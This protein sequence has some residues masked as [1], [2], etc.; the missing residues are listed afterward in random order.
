M[1][2]IAWISLD[3]V[4]MQF[5]NQHGT[6]LREELEKR[7][8]QKMSGWAVLL[9]VYRQR[10]KKDQEFGEIRF[11][12]EKWVKRKGRWRP[13]ARIKLSFKN[14]VDLQELADEW[15]VDADE[16]EVDEEAEEE[17]DDDDIAAA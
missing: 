10:K 9:F 1:P 5:E 11:A 17:A 13:Y 12:I 15:I 16:E 7:V 4:T 2:E 3:S 6:V 8:I 14:M